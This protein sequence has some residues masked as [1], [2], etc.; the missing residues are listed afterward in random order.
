M[1]NMK[2][3][4][5]D[6]TGR[7]FIR[8]NGSPFFYMAD[9][10][11]SAPQKLTREEWEYYLKKRSRQQFNTIQICALSEDDGLFKPNRYGSL[12]FFINGG[13]ISTEPD[14]RQEYNYWKHL[15]WMIDKA[16]QCGMM[17]ALLPTWGDKFNREPH[18]IGPEVFD[19]DR[20]YQY[21][22]WIGERYSHF[23]NIIWVLGGDRALRTQRHYCVIAEMA[24]GI[25]E[26]DSNHLMTF[27]PCG[28]KSSID[29]LTDC[30]F[31]DFHSIQ[32]G[33]GL[34]CYDSWRMVR[35]T[36]SQ[37]PKPCLD[38]ECRY[39]DFPA[40]FREEIGYCWDDADIRQNIYWNML[41]G[42]CGL[43]YG[44]RSV[45]RF[46]PHHSSAYPFTWKEALERPGAQQMQYAERLRMSRPFLEFRAAP[47][48][49]EDY[50]EPNAHIGAGRGGEYAFFYSPLGLP[51]KIH[52][53]PFARSPVR[54]SWFDPRTGTE[55][56]FSVVD[57]KT[58]L[59]VPPASG[60]GNDWILIADCM[61]GKKRK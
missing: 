21:G 47:E 34:E 37:E 39:E 4:K 6:T 28:A 43:T 42:A 22:K 20:A 49:I 10:A 51:I 29:F 16:G 7:F 55:T 56:P 35:K 32:S 40:C 3:I 19:G 9:T 18:G 48:L 57:A 30:S 41:E 11:W 61:A 23:E 8:Q 45:W 27:H 17:I 36:L 25:L 54:L 50:E 1:M 60:K 24:R 44:H 13:N 58:Q 46:E 2:P 52:L 53:E 31:L 33:H 38:M 15:D 59:V 12:P 14:E 26:S 5:I